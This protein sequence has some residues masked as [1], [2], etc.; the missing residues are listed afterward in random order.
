[1]CCSQNPL[2]TLKASISVANGRYPIKC[3][4][5]LIQ[6]MPTKLHATWEIMNSNYYYVSRHFLQHR[7]EWVYSKIKKTHHRSI[8]HGTFTLVKYA[9]R[10]ILTNSGCVQQLAALSCCIDTCQP[11][12]SRVYRMQKAMFNIPLN[13]RWVTLELLVFLHAVHG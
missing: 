6:L 8:T 7:A 2:P 9:S 11:H 5:S 13:I 1:M 12:H 10:M 3:W 4:M